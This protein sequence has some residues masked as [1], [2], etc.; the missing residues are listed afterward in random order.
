MA[1]VV[2]ILVVATVIVIV[3]NGIG[4]TVIVIVNNVVITELVF[5]VIFKDYLL[6]SV[7]VVMVNVT[8]VKV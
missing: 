5:V 4:D 7:N 3:L 1:D 2:T 6:G 8:V